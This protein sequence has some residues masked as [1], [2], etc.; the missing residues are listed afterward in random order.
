MTRE[1]VEIESRDPWSAAEIGSPTGFSRPQKIFRTAVRV[2]GNDGDFGN[3]ALL[4]HTPYYEADLPFCPAERK[5]SC[6]E[7]SGG[8]IVA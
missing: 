3:T 6:R 4:L 1:M 5:M 7:V 2:R 8:A